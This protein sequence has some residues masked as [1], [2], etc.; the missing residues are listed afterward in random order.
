MDLF[1]IWLFT[2]LTAHRKEEIE[3]PGGRKQLHVTVPP[4]AHRHLT[5]SSESESLNTSVHLP[6]TVLQH[7]RPTTRSQLH[8]LQRNVMTES[9]L[10]E[11]WDTMGPHLPSWQHEFVDFCLSQEPSVR[12][13][14]DCGNHPPPHLPEDLLRLICQED[15]PLQTTTGGRTCLRRLLLADDKCSKVRIEHHVDGTQP[16][17]L[18]TWLDARATGLTPAAGVPGLM[19]FYWC[20]INALKEHAVPF[21]YY[22]TCTGNNTR[23]KTRSES[24]TLTFSKDGC[25]VKA[26]FIDE[27]CL[28]FA[29]CGTVK[30]YL[31]QQDHLKRG[32]HDAFTNENKHAHPMNPKFSNLPWFSHELLPGQMLIVSGA[33]CA[34]LYCTG[35]HLCSA[36][37]D[38][39]IH[40][41]FLQLVTGSFKSVPLLGHCAMD[42]I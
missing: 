34:S 21:R 38:D 23:S 14:C 27:A 28:H 19:L 42:F 20:A 26:V 31:L 6:Y 7:G 33:C 12:V 3:N 40:H 25:L 8:G 15:I 9:L 32:G 22:I 18:G 41:I 13:C 4:T 35:Y 39:D 1:R 2:A 29:L 30:F 16:F 17:P 5:K 10:V 37:T 11:A 36:H 24:V